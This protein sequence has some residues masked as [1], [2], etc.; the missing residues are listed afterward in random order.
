MSEMM[1]E[2]PFAT[3]VL[4]SH[5]QA[6]IDFS[7]TTTTES[8]SANERFSGRYTPIQDKLKIRGPW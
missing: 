4:S 7:Y 8:F 1:I 3:K 6:N 5:C 2:S